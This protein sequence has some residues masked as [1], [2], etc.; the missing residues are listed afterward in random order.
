M[1]TFHQNAE[2]FTACF[3]C[4]INGLETGA[5]F[6]GN[7]WP[8]L[9][10]CYVQVEEVAVQNC[11][12]TASYYSDQIKESLEVEPV[13]PVEDV[14]CTVGAQGKQIVTG[15]GLSLACLADHEELRGG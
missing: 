9:T 3:Y 13:D 12:D 2:P 5:S 4:T 15:D 11:L 14:Q 10:F 6:W 7:F 8:H 1:D